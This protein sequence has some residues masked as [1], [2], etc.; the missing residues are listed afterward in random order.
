MRLGRAGGLRCFGGGG[1]WRWPRRGGEDVLHVHM[2]EMHEREDDGLQPKLDN[3][4]N[5]FRMPPRVVVL[6][7][8]PGHVGAGFVNV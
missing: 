1:W 3:I 2:P 4:D 8:G 7:S 5:V 6:V